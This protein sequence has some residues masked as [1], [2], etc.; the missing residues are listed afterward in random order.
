VVSYALSEPATTTWSIARAATGIRR[1][2]L[3]V[4]ARRGARGGKHCIRYVRLAGTVTHLDKAGTDRVRFS[5]WLRGRRLRRGHYRL[6]VVPR[7]VAG[8]VGSAA[9][10]RVAILG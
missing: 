4:T 5:G 2:G 7:D 1:R 8:N 9:T 3:C 10:T 6:T